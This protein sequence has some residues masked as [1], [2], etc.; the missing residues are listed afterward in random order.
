MKTMNKKDIVY[1]KEN[2][3]SPKSIDAV[4]EI[5][6]KESEWT[7]SLSSAMRTYNSFLIFV[8]NK[9]FFTQNE[10]SASLLNINSSKAIKT[11]KEYITNKE[12]IRSQVNT[13]SNPY[14]KSF[15]TWSSKWHIFDNWAENEFKDLLSERFVLYLLEYSDITKMFKKPISEFFCNNPEVVIKAII[16]NQKSLIN[17]NSL[18]LPFSGDD[19]YII[20]AVEN[21]LASSDADYLE[22]RDVLAF[23]KSKKIK[24]DNSIIAKAHKYSDEKEKELFAE[25]GLHKWETRIQFTPG[26]I[27]TE[28]NAKT[29]AFDS[30]ILE[31]ID[32]PRQFFFA[33][34]KHFNM[35]DENYIIPM[36][37]NKPCSSFTEMLSIKRGGCYNQ[38]FLSNIIQSITFSTFFAM[39]SFLKNQNINIEEFAINGFSQLFSEITESVCFSFKEKLEGSFYNKTINLLLDID[40]LSKAYSSY[41]KTGTIDVY[42]ISSLSNMNFEDTPSILPH[43]Y[44]KASVPSLEAA[45]SFLF[46]TDKSIQIDDSLPIKSNFNLFLEHNL[47]PQNI[48]SYNIPIIKEL[49]KYNCI[50]LNPDG[51]IK[52]TNISLILAPLHRSGYL[53]YNDDNLQLL[54]DFEIS[55]TIFEDTLF[56]SDE[57]EYI[58][59]LLR[60]KYGD[61]LGIR[62][63][64]MHGTGIQYSNDAHEYNYYIILYILLV[65]ESKILIDL[66]AEK[67]K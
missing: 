64:Y 51:F 50:I 17:G 24:I 28:T 29:I 57:K 10:D 2:T 3:Y 5:L 7:T 15:L 54:N 21:Y 26:G 42:F 33:F 25:I 62:N 59:Y 49:A 30:S 22:I 67:E 32:S 58:K 45:L 1:Y 19:V 36:A 53:L 16:K 13:L 41:V 23:I 55:K 4:I 66:T 38:T 44:I 61:S 20:N 9:E 18:Y 63:N 35:I 31:K 14:L 37:S 6:T 56:C 60:D 27:P 34:I 47:T 65:L 8:N 43:K 52:P 39:T 46:D 40:Y 12:N 48:A 11:I